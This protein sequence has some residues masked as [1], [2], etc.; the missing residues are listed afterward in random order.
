M[1]GE[2]CLGPQPG[3]FAL[4]TVDLLL[5]LVFGGASFVTLPFTVGAAG[6]VLA[7]RG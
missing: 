4:E 6:A 1:E 3:G 7:V 2:S 5:G